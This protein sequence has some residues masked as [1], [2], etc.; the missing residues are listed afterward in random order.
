V[1]VE[2]V[3]EEEAREELND[4]CHLDEPARLD[5]ISRRRAPTR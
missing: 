5:R 2:R 1:K 3:K 4:E